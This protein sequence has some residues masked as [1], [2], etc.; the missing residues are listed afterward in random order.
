MN[1]AA[2]TVLLVGGLIATST[3]VAAHRHKPQQRANGHG[4][5]TFSRQLRVFRDGRLPTTADHH[6]PTCARPRQRAG[7]LLG[8]ADRS[9]RPN[10]PARRNPGPLPRDRHGKRH[11]LRTQRG[12]DRHR[13][14]RI[15]LGQTSLQAIRDARRRGSRA[16]ANR[17]PGGLSNRNGKRERKRKP[18]PGNRR[19]RRN[20]TRRSTSRHPHPN[21]AD[22]HR[23]TAMDVA[24]ER[25]SGTAGGRPPGWL[26]RLRRSWAAVAHG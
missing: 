20:R 10:P 8:R 23:L 12:R 21:D 1:R 18:D 5:T 24:G 14:A 13:R 26:G 2:V 25:R 7:D 3:S 22:D 4:P 6:R 15:P 16:V 11:F 17:R 19:V 9:Q